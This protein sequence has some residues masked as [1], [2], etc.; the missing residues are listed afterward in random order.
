L[1]RAPVFRSLCDPIHV[2]KQANATFKIAGRLLP[3]GSEAELA[4]LAYGV[5]A[6]AAL[7]V[8]YILRKFL[9]G[10]V[11]GNHAVQRGSRLL[12]RRLGLGDSLL[13]EKTKN[14]PCK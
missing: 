2:G 9:L 5:A 10:F 13:L 7:R 12:R 11:G 8:E 14:Q 3:S 6:L 1:V 4:V